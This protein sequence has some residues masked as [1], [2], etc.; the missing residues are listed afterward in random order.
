MIPSDSVTFSTVLAILVIFAQ[1]CIVILLFGLFTN[2]RHIINFFGRRAFTL[3][4]VVV[5]TAVIGPITYSD[6]FNMVPCKLC[7][8]QRI[9]IFPQ[10]VLLIT[11][12]IKRY[13][14]EV[15]SY[16]MTFA[17][18]AICISIFHYILQM[19]DAP[20]ISSLA[21]CNVTGQAP[22]CSSFYVLMFGYIT[23]PMMAMTTSASTLLL[24]LAHK[25]FQRT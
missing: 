8:Y 2:N 5:C 16:L 20:A 7:W 25:R 14:T 21:P 24:M 19:T 9:F 15:V 11:A 3:A 22:S 17:T 4:T 13:R 23:I 10:A 12:L 1:L 6:V 18:I